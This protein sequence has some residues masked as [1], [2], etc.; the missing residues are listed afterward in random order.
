[1]ICGSNIDGTT[2]YLSGVLLNLDLLSLPNSWTLCYSATYVTPLNT[3]SIASI[4]SLCNQDKLLIG[5]R[6]VGSTILTVAAIGNRS[7]VLYDCGSSS[8]CKHEAN[9][10]GWYFSDSYSW[11]F[12]SGNDAVIRGPCDTES[13]NG[14]SRLC[15]PTQGDGGFRCGSTINLGSS[16]TWMK[17]IFQSN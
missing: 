5:C 11:G 17:V 3:L 4:L 10:I 1:M 13:T 8:N 15:W 9:G 7:D 14:G 12:A 2:L 16:I 6:P